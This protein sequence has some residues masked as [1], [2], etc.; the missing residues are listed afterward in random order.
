VQ[1]SSFARASV[2]TRRLSTRVW[3]PLWASA[4][5]AALTAGCT[6]EKAGDSMRAAD[7]AEVSQEVTVEATVLAVDQEKR[8][9][10]LQRED[11]LIFTVLAGPAVRNLP[12][13]AVGDK[14]RAIYEE[15]LLAALKKPGEAVAPPVT[16]VALNRAE[17][18]ATPR[19]A[20]GQ[21]VT[22]TV[23]IESVDTK[24]NIVAFTPPS[25][26]TRA[27]R[28]E[29]PEFQEYIKGLK[30]GDLVEVTYTEAM[31]IAVEKATAK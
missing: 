18:G 27:I 26:G 3:M 20:A 2:L 16:T 8:L 24:K 9:V 11:G 23:R 22:C 30:P 15:S 14:V 25:G 13:V 21:Q 6:S 12:Q 29:R 5:A 1:R 19:G 28:V 10:T 4:I 31:A 17:P 7:S